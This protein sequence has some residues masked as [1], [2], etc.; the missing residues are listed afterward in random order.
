MFKL[1]NSL[2]LGVISILSSF[3]SCSNFDT[4]K[5]DTPRRSLVT[6]NGVN[7]VNNDDETSI[8][9]AFD[10]NLTTLFF[11]T[12][13]RISSTN[14]LANFKDVNNPEVS[15]NYRLR[16]DI[17]CN[18]YTA[19]N[20]ATGYIDLYDNRDLFLSDYP[21]L[22]SGRLGNGGT[23]FAFVN[24]IPSNTKGPYRFAA[25]DY[26]VD[27]GYFS[28]SFQ[29]IPSNYGGSHFDLRNNEYYQLGFNWHNT[30]SMNIYFDTMSS[31]GEDIVFGASTPSEFV[32]TII[33]YPQTSSPN[34]QGYEY[35]TITYDRLRAPVYHS[36]FNL[37][38]I[39]CIENSF[40]N[41]TSTSHPTMYGY[42][43]QLSSPYDVAYSIYS[44]I[45][46]N[47]YQDGYNAG[48]NAGLNNGS[49]QS[50]SFE[51]A[52]SFVGSV[53]SPVTQVL[54]VEVFSGITLGT[55]ISIP[56]IFGLLWFVIRH[57]TS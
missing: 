43:S 12:S 21:Y 29:I 57:L 40:S 7:Y 49:S 55:L 22:S 26:F 35:S 23:F 52:F 51:S 19:Y 24:G 32:Y 13:Y 47:S 25:T 46:S 5:L 33:P 3:S 17:I 50:S 30:Y 39:N 54:N 15:F 53:I 8:W 11:P 28:T 27:T 14:Y 48:Y 31:S 10:D 20:T 34:F 9:Y 18:F 41:S 36:D 37:T 2:S 56:L 38:T 6:E 16:Y 4:I 42:L 45:T 1:L 44:S